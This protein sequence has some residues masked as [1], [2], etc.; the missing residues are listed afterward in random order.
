MT[1]KRSVVLV[2]TAAILSTGLAACAQSQRESGGSSASGSASGGSTF[3]FG[4]AGAPKVFDPFYATDGETF[5]VSRQ[6]FEGLVTFKPGTADPAP[7]LAKEWSASPDGLTWTFS[8]QEGVKFTDGTDF[9]A[10]AV[11]KNFER[12]YS[13]TGAAATAAVSQYW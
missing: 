2:A 3:T 7:S 8:L 9:N 13:Q 6:M 10:D 4:A 1:A 12:M 5:R 11:C